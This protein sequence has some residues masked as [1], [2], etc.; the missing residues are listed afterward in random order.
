[1]PKIISNEAE[2]KVLTLS[3][4]G[5]TY[6]YIKQR[7]NEDGVDICVR[8]ITR[9]IKNVGISRQ[10]K[11]KGLLKPKYRRPPL[12]RT[13]AMIKK[14]KSLVNKKN[15]ETW[16][17]IA[18]VTG[19]THPTIS[20]IMYKDLGLVKRKKSGV[21]KLSTKHQTNRKTNCRKLYEKH[22]AGDKSEF[23]VTLDEALVYLKNSNGERKICYL[24]K[25]ED[26]PDDW[27]FENGESFSKGFM[28]IGVITG[29]GTVPL[30]QVPPKAKVNAEY[31]IEYVLKPLFKNHLPRL[32]GNDINKVFFHHDK[33]SS[34]TAGL[35][36][37]YLKQMKK[38]LGISYLEKHEIP[39]KS[40]DASPLDFFGFGYLKQ[41][42]FHRKATTLA[43]VW[44]LCQEIWSEIDI[45]LVKRVF[46][47]WKKRCRMISSRDGR[48]IENIKNI[49]SKS[50]SLN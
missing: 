23:A 17:T 24:A 20:T 42:L 8:T 10:A 4:E 5:N 9:M 40:P 46:E 27:V 26:V 38:E 48:H 6:Q 7:L 28:V 45:D 15:P 43:G 22:L 11:S 49:H 19:L 13:P 16:R 31:Y 18:K 35:T 21:H 30:F 25:G 1:M 47:S 29:R 2:T 33:A 37:D 3:K 50:I 44:K 41:K 12:K 39:V 34:H 32:Y 14:V 36:I